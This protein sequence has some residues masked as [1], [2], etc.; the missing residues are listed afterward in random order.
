MVTT[1]FV[2]KTTTI[3][4]AW[5]N[6]IDAAVYDAVVGFIPIPLHSLRETTNFDVSNIAANG[7]ILASDTTPIMDAINVATD[8]CQRI[9]WAS[10]NNDQVVFQAPLPPYIDTTADLVIH[11]RIVSGGTTDAVGF[12]FASFFNEAD[13]SV[14][15]TSGTNQT[16]T[17]AEV[18]ATIAAADI[19][20]GAQTLTCGLTPV[21]HTTDTLAMSSIW[22]EYTRVSRNAQG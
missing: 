14:A 9:L 17:Y 4:T 3:E 8:G 18:V 20:S 10:S 16:T 7:G 22:I 6:D 13:T 5:L 19:P 2:N 12:T 15:D 11:M 21:A 1:T